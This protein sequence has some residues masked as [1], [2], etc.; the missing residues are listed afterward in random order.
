MSGIYSLVANPEITY[1]HALDGFAWEAV[2]KKVPKGEDVQTQ[3]EPL[4]D[5]SSSIRYT[6]K[7]P[8]PKAEMQSIV[9]GMLHLLTTIPPRYIKYNKVL[10]AQVD[11]SLQ[12]VDELNIKLDE[13]YQNLHLAYHPSGVSHSTFTS[14]LQY[15]I[16][17]IMYDIWKKV[18]TR[19]APASR[20]FNVSKIYTLHTLEK[21]EHI[22]NCLSS[23]R[24]ILDRDSW[25]KVQF[26]AVQFG[27]ER[28]PKTQ[29]ERAIMASLSP[30]NENAGNRMSLVLDKPG[31]FGNSEEAELSS[32]RI[33]YL[34]EVKKSKVYR[35]NDLKSILDNMLHL[36]YQNSSYP[37]TYVRQ[38]IEKE[39]R[40]C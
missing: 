26:Y 39:F 23:W 11:S 22:L 21:A 24:R 34:N 10:S 3:T 4:N 15:R 18:W 7:L 29:K 33:E 31:S 35:N 17:T 8:L 1:D 40:V 36:R 27:L 12:S 30:N 13:A 32:F 14:Y 38:A 16:L 25:Q 6:G 9:E 19:F 20:S 37:T 28:S 2:K 5:I